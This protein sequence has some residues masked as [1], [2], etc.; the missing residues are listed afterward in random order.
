MIVAVV[1]T[2]VMV[3]VM[4]ITMQT[5]AVRMAAFVFMACLLYTSDAADE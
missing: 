4:R 3:V 2:M 5:A 1:V